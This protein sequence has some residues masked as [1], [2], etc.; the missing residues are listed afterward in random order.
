S[1]AFWQRVLGGARQAIGRP[2]L[3]N[4]HRLTVIGVMPRECAFR[5]GTEMW[6]PL[7]EHF[8]F[9]NA[10]YGWETIARLKPGVAAVAVRNA[11]NAQFADQAKRQGVTSGDELC[12]APVH[13]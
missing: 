6:V 2:L 4:G 8:G 11:L 3:A 9:F 5:G 7:P 10:S 12:V 1:H 13:A